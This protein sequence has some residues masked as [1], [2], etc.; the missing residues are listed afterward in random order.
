[1]IT[2]WR[3]PKDFSPPTAITGIVN[4]VCSK[5]L[6]SFASWDKAV[7]C[8]NPAR[9]PPGCA[10]HFKDQR[11]QELCRLD[12]FGQGD[13][14]APRPT[15]VTAFRKWN[16]LIPITG[17]IN[18]THDD[19]KPYKQLFSSDLRYGKKMRHMECIG[20]SAKAFDPTAPSPKPIR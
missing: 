2:A 17:T 13:E 19:L 20:V 18:R 16:V 10:S 9:I 7:N 5:S 1:M 6:L 4:L 14:I 3:G 15:H 12:R 8:A 11:I